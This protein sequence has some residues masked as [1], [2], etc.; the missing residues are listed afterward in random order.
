MCKN[1]CTSKLGKVCRLFDTLR[2]H[3][4]PLTDDD[5]SPEGQA[6]AQKIGTGTRNKDRSEKRRLGSRNH[7]GQI[8]V[9]SSIPPRGRNRRFFSLALRASFLFFFLL[10]LFRSLA[11]TLGER[12]FSWSWNSNL[13]R[14]KVKGRAGNPWG[15]CPTT[16][17]LTQNYQRAP[18]PPRSP[19]PPPVRFSWGRASLTVIVLPPIWV[20]FSEVIAFW[21]SSEVAIS[22]KPKPRAWPVTLSVMTFAEVTAPCCENSSCNCCSVTEYGNPPTYNLILI[23][24]LLRNPM[25]S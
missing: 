20:P 6:E 11:I 9:F 17:I 25:L 16:V 21:A 24:L 19:I 3:N 13:L 15:S 18:L 12:G 22:T 23:P 10:G 14:S 1:L 5:T 7:A 8:R 4:A 2:I